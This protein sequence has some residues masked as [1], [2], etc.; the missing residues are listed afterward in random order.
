[1]VLIY[2]LKKFCSIID[3]LSSSNISIKIYGNYSEIFIGAHAGFQTPP[4]NTFS[5]KFVALTS[6][7]TFY[8]SENI[9]LSDI[10]SIQSAKALINSLSITEANI[11]LNRETGIITFS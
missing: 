5:I 11:S 10:D 6:I 7:G 8:C 4:N 1:M 9:K 2:N 3:D